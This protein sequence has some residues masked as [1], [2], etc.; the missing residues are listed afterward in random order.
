MMDRKYAPA[1]RMYPPFAETAE[2]LLP[3]ADTMHHRLTVQVTAPVLFSYVWYVLREAE[4]L[5]IRRLYF[6]ARDGCVMLKIAQEIAKVCPV[7]PELRYLYC[8]RASLRMPSYHRIPEQEMMDLL[9]HRGTSLT[10]SHIL[11]RAHLTEEERHA[12]LSH[13]DA[14]TDIDFSAERI[15]AP[16]SENDFAAVCDTLRSDEM[17]RDL[18]LCHSREAHTAAMSYFRQEGLTDGTPF[19]IVD[20]GWT[21]SMQRS[22]R[23]ISD[24]IPA[25]TGFYFGMF[26]R[27]KE[28]DDGVYRT[29]Y[30]SADSSI[31]IRTKF[32]NNLFEC[33]CAA[34][35]DMTIGYEQDENGRYQPVFRPAAHPDTAMQKTIEAQISICSA[36][37][38]A[39]APLISYAECP[40]SLHDLSRRLLQ[41]LMYAPTAEEAESY[42]VFTFCDD[43]TEAYAQSLVQHD[44]IQA[45]QEHMPFRRAWRRYKGMKPSKEL[46]WI[47][48]T[49]AVSSLPMQSVR[50]PLLRLWDVIRCILDQRKSI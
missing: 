1:L 48:G 4:R 47:Y 18:V 46:Y 31:S 10:I 5:G 42:E 39:C 2:Q 38:A 3:H 29:W 15:H 20:T 43:V 19:G 8:S 28:K 25:M 7:Q 30:F 23:Q 32:N 14:C 13:L 35:H 6:L 49:L 11:D 40:A 26:A 16:L 27:P 9:L 34:P 37:A 12:L 50:R 24:E 33:M 22:L 36:F 44:C 45:L 21:G 17:F 41:A